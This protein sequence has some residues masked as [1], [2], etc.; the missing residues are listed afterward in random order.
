MSS[1]CKM[2]SDTRVMPGKSIRAFAD[3]LADQ[4]AA[5][6]SKITH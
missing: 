3:S 2:L 6:R 4:N 1:S 5:Q